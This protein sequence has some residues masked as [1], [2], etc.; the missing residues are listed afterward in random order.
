V[1]ERPAPVS[2]ATFSCPGST[3][4]ILGVALTRPEFK[5]HLT[6]NT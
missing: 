5:G 4:S 3:H 6:G 2:S 1:R